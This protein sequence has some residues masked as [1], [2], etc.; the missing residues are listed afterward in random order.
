[1]ARGSTLGRLEHPPLAPGRSGRRD[2][3]APPDLEGLGVKTFNRSGEDDALAAIRTMLRNP[4]PTVE[5]DAPS[6]PWLEGLIA[7]TDYVLRCHGAA[8]VAGGRPSPAGSGSTS[9]ASHPERSESD[10]GGV[11]Q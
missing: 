9:R 5:D 3:W 7:M 8:P 6:Q 10:P 4:P 2:R 1:M 11:N